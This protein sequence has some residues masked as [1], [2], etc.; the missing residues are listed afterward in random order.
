MNGQITPEQAE[1]LLMLSSLVLLAVVMR[2][3]GLAA[4]RKWFRDVAPD[5]L[6]QEERDDRRVTHRR[7]PR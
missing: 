1:T 5:N 2:L 4:W 3:V 6:T 7:R